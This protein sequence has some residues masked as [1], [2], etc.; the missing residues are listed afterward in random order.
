[1]LSF[2]KS[3]DG[4]ASTFE[5]ILSV[6]WHPIVFIVLAVLIYY[7]MTMLAASLFSFYAGLVLGFKVVF[8]RQMRR[9][10]TDEE[11]TEVGL[12]FFRRK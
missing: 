5:I 12:W 9:T 7:D 6:T 3:K 4:E 2:F 1:M 11:W 8:W 10:L